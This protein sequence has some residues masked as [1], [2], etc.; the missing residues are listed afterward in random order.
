MPGIVRLSVSIRIVVSEKKKMSIKV[1]LISQ[2][3]YFPQIKK[4]RVPPHIISRANKK[5]K[6]VSNGA[7]HM[8]SKLETSINVTPS[9]S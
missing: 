3:F 5:S 2:F 1:C 8:H 4:T 6:I 7:R 9:Q